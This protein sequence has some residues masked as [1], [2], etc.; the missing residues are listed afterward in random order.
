MKKRLKSLE[1]FVMRRVEEIVEND[2]AHQQ[3]DDK[4]AVLEEKLMERI[5]TEIIDEIKVM[6]RLKTEQIIMIIQKFTLLLL[7]TD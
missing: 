1:E 6:E 4:I 5:P 3:L 2:K 7:M